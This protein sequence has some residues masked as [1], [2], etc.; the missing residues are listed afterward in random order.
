[1]TG[2]KR[3]EKPENKARHYFDK[4]ELYNIIVDWQDRCEA[5]RKE[6]KEEPRMP[7]SIGAAIIETA[8]NMSR[9]WNFSGY[10]F[11]EDMVLEGILAATRATFSFDRNNP[12]KNPFGFFSFVIWRSFGQYITNEK[13]E[14]NNRKELFLDENY[15]SY[16]TDITGHEISKHGLIDHYETN[17]F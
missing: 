9:R 13:K 1:M 6:G 12:K 14:Y 3:E 5:A 2:I 10:P 7:D 17:S 16:E 8:E 15:D 11:R 4:E